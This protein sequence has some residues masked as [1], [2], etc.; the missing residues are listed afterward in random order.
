MM[1]HKPTRREARVERGQ[2][3]E[4]IGKEGTGVGIDRQR[5][6]D[7]AIVKTIKHV[8]CVCSRNAIVW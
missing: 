4:I 3:R 7:P 1:G 5:S 6:H 2:A 8:L